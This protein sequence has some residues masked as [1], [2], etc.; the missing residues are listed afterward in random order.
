MSQSALS[1]HPALALAQQLIQID[2]VTPDDKGA[3]PLIQSQL[4][5]LG[6]A[7]E[8]LVFEEVTNLWTLHTAR[9]ATE[10]APVFV[11]AGHT[12][13]VPTG[14]IEEWTHTPFSGLID[15]QGWLHGRGSA[16]MKS[17][18]AAFVVA[19]RRFIQDYPDYH[20]QIALL[21]TSD[22][23][24]PAIHGTK[25]V[26]DTLQQ[27]G[28]RL[29][30]CLV[31]EPTCSRQLGDVV[32]N[33]RRGSM[34][35]EL[36]VN[37]IQGHI[38]YPH[39]AQNPVHTLAP[40][41]TELVNTQWDQGNANFPP[42][43]FQV[44]NLH[45]GTGAT[46]VIPGHCDLM[47]NFRFCTEQTPESLQDRVCQILDK[48]GLDYELKWTVSGLPFETPAEGELVQAIQ[49]AIH[50]HTGLASKLDTGG[51]TS[52]GRFIAPTGAQVLEFGPLNATIHKINEKVVAQDI[53]DLT[54]IYYLTL[55][56][57][58]IKEPEQ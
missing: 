20:G 33:G 50:T 22:E 31:G 11:F 37:G 43:S 7:P 10:Q 8:T 52:D 44:S 54:E 18:I 19:C 16:D 15:E 4:S 36:R 30:Y 12:D 46:N 57:L 35:G 3:Q 28:Q 32:K 25:A 14:P 41:L 38:A 5:E 55:K 26:I 40:A 49:S 2:S 56:H 1:D 27:R 45:A 17:S 13:V 47:F 6:F 21:I 34:T 53:I 23:E 48:H 24:G 39:L 51:G 9:N 42:T 58:F 29:D